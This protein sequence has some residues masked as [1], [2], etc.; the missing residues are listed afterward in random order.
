[1]I[2][3]LAQALGEQRL[4]ERV[5]D[6]VRARVREV[7][8][9]EPD[10]VARARSESRGGVR[11]RRGPPDEVGAAIE[12]ARRG[13]P[14]R[15]A[16]AATPPRARRAPGSG[17]R[18]RSGRRT[19]RSGRAR[20]GRG[21]ERVGHPAS[22]SRMRAAG[23]AARISASPTS[24]ASAPAGL[25]PFDVVAGRHAAL[26][27]PRRGRREPGR[28]APAPR[29]GSTSRVSRSRQ[30]TPI[31]GAPSGPLHLVLGVAFDQGAHARDPRRRRAG[32]AARHR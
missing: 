15:R 26:E 5:V 20:R 8:A 27:H 22:S 29:P 13:S 6:L 30:F 19:R 16:S 12:R 11:E 25:R 9:L 17:P 1:M 4:A 18:G 23:S 28:A 21:C 14:G 31:T 10:A 7:L 2:R 24:T 32:R 3:A